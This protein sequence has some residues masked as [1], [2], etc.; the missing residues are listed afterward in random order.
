M[1]DLEMLTARYLVE[2]Y[3]KLV[4]QSG[5]TAAGMAYRWAVWNSALK[6]ELGDAVVL[7]AT[8]AK[9]LRNTIEEIQK[10]PL[11]AWVVAKLDALWKTVEKLAAVC[12]FDGVGKQ[13]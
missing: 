12:G 3:A 8:S 13:S 9:Q 5:N 7:G 4:K 2:E 10:G 6:A 11:E 1:L